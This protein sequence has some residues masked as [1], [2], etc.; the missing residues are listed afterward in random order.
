M[1]EN[2]VRKEKVQQAKNDFLNFIYFAEQLQSW[3]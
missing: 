3:N 1:Y 2:A